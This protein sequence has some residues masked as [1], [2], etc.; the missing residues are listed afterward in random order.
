MFGPWVMQAMLSNAQTTFEVVATGFAIQLGQKGAAVVEMAGY[1]EDGMVG[2]MVREESGEGQGRMR[3]CRI[4]V[5][6][7]HCFQTARDQN[8]WLI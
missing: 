6:N 4:V 5:G 7:I 2:M 1:E 8:I 3:P